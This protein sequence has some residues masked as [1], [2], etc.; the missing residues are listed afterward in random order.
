VY[1]ICDHPGVSGRDYHEHMRW[2]INRFG[3]VVQGVEREGM[4]PPWAYTIGL[5]GRRRPELVVTGIGL[6]QAIEMLNGMAAHLMYAHA[7]EPGAQATL[8]DGSLV[9]IVKVAVPWAHLSM[10]VEFYGRHIRG[11]QLVH[12]DERGHWPWDRRYRG[13]PGGQPILGTR[14]PSR[15][16]KRAG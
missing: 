9:E 4:R 1:W 10:A 2:L 3:W 11:L 8:P 16:R 12:A 7:P 15:R 14:E 5:T 6:N 13:V